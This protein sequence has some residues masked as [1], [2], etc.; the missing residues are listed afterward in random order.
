MSAACHRPPRIRPLSRR[1]SRRPAVE[2]LRTFRRTS[3]ADQ[4]TQAGSRRDSPA[5]TSKP[6]GKCLE[7]CG[8]H[9]QHCLRT[10]GERL[11]RKLRKDP[12][13]HPQSDKVQVLVRPVITA[14]NLSDSAH[15]PLPQRQSHVKQIACAL[16]RGTA[17]ARHIHG[18]RTPARLRERCSSGW[19]RRCR[20]VST[21]NLSEKLCKSQATADRLCTCAAV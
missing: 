19:A 1:R 12:R 21:S 13:P 11:R 7:M 17:S 3:K 14:G 10:Y 8:N 5:I 20:S 16:T 15:P 18:P 2:V 4:R 9:K 6:S